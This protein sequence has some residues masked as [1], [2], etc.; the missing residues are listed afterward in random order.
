M[1][2]LRA[3]G[4]SQWASSISCQRGYAKILKNE[5]RFCVP[6]AN[7]THSCDFRDG[8]DT[9]VLL[10]TS[11]CS[12]N[13]ERP[14][15]T[16]FHEFTS[17][18]KFDTVIVW[19]RPHFF[20]PDCKNLPICNETQKYV[21]EKKNHCNIKFIQFCRLH[22]RIVSSLTISLKYNFYLFCYFSIIFLFNFYLFLL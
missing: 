19:I 4:P 6:N 10:R 15:S 13:K 21:Q 22:K 11:R 20:S 16:S 12:G 18:V 2:T 14:I 5:V 1:F 7:Q 8:G 3:I 9:I 17:A